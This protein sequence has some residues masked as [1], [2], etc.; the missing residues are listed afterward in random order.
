MNQIASPSKKQK[1]K[2]YLPDLE[3]LLS[4]CEVNYWLSQ[5]I[6][7]GLFELNKSGCFSKNLDKVFEASSKVVSLKGRVTDLA[8]YTTTMNLTIDGASKVINKPIS[9]IVR[10]YHDAKMMEVMEGTGPG[11]L[12]A[13]YFENKYKKQVDEKRQVNQFVGECFR[14]CLK[15]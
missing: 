12:K 14:A 9:L 4:Q 8:R 5:Q 15:K 2:A 10:F 6:W 11:T 1:A 13:V 3:Q 7:P